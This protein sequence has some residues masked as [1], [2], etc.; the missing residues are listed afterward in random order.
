MAY[1]ICSLTDID[2][3]DLRPLRDRAN[4]F[5]HAGLWGVS[6]DERHR[7]A[8]EEGDIVLL[9]LAAPVRQFVARAVVASRVHEWTPVEARQYPGNATGGVLLSR[10]EVWDPPV[11]MSAVLPQVDPAEKAKADFDTGVVRITPGEYE[12][13]IEVAAGV[14]DSRS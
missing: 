9:Y 14:A 10:V 6:V 5:L 7:E 13:A 4:D 2:V 11:A 3:T 8:L 1:Y 12:T